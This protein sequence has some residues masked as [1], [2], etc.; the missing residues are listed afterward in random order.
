MYLTKSVPTGRA[1][2]KLI[3]ICFR[4]HN[5]GREPRR[6]KEHERTFSNVIFKSSNFANLTKA[7]KIPQ[8]S[9]HAGCIISHMTTSAVW[10]VLHCCILLYN[11][12]WRGLAELL[13]SV[14]RQCE[15]LT[16]GISDESFSHVFLF[17]NITEY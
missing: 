16:I 6:G 1:G 11:T 17:P 2:Q 13:I 10:T 5:R 12:Q 9:V 3:G 14:H 15:G 8:R 7:L 4:C